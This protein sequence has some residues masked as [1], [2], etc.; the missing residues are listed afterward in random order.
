[1]RRLSLAP[2]FFLF[3]IIIQAQDWV[4]LAPDNKKV[5]IENEHFRLVE[6][7]LLPGKTEP[8]HSHPEYIE[9]FLDS[10]KMIVVYPGKKPIEWKVEK[11]KAY[12]GPPEPPHSIMNAEKYPVRLLLTEFKDR[13]YK[14]E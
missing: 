3:P 13:P 10:A 5:L 11:N 6:I 1:M 2:L 9:Y 7:T 14:K 4:K 12:S 8:V